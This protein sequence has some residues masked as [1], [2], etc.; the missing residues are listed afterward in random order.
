M[1]TLT[2]SARACA[3][4]LVCLG[5]HG[6]PLVV[7][8]GNLSE[9]RLWKLRDLM[10]SGMRADGCTLRFA[11][12]HVSTNWSGRPLDETYHREEALLFRAVFRALVTVPA[13]ARGERATFRR[14]LYD[15]DEF[16]GTSIVERI[17]TLA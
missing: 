17:G 10:R 7:Y 12:I 2:L 9:T 14:R 13:L 1:V 4:V 8:N 5:H 16:L 11:H 15:L 6:E 3:R